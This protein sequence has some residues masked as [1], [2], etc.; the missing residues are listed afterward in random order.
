MLIN[1]WIKVT[2][3]VFFLHEEQESIVLL[4]YIR[5]RPHLNRRVTTVVPDF[6]KSRKTK[7]ETWYCEQEY[8]PTTTNGPPGR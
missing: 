5:Q 3:F 6:E 4:V 2:K 7:R 8:E 1:Y